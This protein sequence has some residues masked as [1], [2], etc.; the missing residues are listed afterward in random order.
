MAHLLLLPLLPLLHLV[1]GAPPPPRGIEVTK[2]HVSSSVQLRYS[3]T[4]VEARMT[5]PTSSTQQASFHLTIPD[6]A[7]IS[8]F[9]LEVAGVEHVAR[10]EER[11]R[12]EALFEVAAEGEEWGGLVEQDSNDPNRFRVT[13]S[14]E[15]GQK[16]VFR[17]AYDEL[18]QRVAAMYHQEIHIDLAAA[19]EDF[20]IEVAIT[21]SLPITEVRVPR[22]LQADEILPKNEPENSLAKIETNVD[23]KTNQ[24]RVVFAPSREEQEEEG[25]QGRLVVRYE[26]DRQ[27]QA[28]EL[29][30]IDGYFI[31][32]FVPEHLPALPKHTVFVLDVSAS[33]VGEK[34]RQLKDAMFTVLDDMTD[35]DYF[36]IVTFGT[37]VYHW[38]DSMSVV[39]ATAASKARAIAFILDLE[40]RGGTNI[41][42]AVLA[43]LW[44]AI[45]EQ[46]NF[47]FQL[48]S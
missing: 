18:L 35:Q 34:L 42:E 36:N 13:T 7:F 39:R 43:G 33:M 45:T 14:V 9:S 26:V 40:E 8:N 32:Y 41:N 27:G 31:H 30:V 19:V 38:E 20:R 24:A 4:R 48:N 46:V 23:G 17:L 44:V 25:V 2:F 11:A 5:N 16:V 3:L 47:P 22:L 12:A 1:S 21:E 37:A 29:Q 6:N 10:V 28:N 15:G